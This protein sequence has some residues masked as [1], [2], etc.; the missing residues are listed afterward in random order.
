MRLISQYENNISEAAMN[1]MLWADS[2]KVLPKDNICP[3]SLY[4]ARR[5]VG[6]TDI[7]K[8]EEHFCTCDKHHFP[9]IA[10]SEWKAHCEETCPCGRRRFKITTG[11][12]M[13]P[14][15]ASE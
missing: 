10:R 14:E 6:F 5:V 13:Q 2:K 15:N 11:G 1:D 9:K 8:Y 3:P 12:H 7:E 4:L